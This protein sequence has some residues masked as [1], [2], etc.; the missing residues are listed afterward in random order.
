MKETLELNRSRHV[1]VGYQPGIRGV[2]G[3]KFSC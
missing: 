2:G 3:M 1:I